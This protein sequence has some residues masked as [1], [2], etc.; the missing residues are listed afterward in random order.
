[1]EKYDANL[2]AQKA[3]G[4]KRF[5][6]TAQRPDFNSTSEQIT[7]VPYGAATHVSRVTLVL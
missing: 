7:N 5:H 4:Y 6:N 2:I 1:M 3:C